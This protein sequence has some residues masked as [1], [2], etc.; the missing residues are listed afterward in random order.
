MAE[1]RD[2]GGV[3]WGPL[4][5]ALAVLAPRRAAER[6]A[7]RV[8]IANLRRGYEARAKTLLTEG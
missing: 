3:P 1:H 6:Y 7:A 4:D 8:A 2:K 5:A